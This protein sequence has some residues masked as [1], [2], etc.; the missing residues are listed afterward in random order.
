M[1]WREPRSVLLAA[2]IAAAVAVSAAVAGDG[3]GLPSLSWSSSHVQRIHTSGAPAP[4]RLHGP[5]V[6]SAGSFLTFRGSVPSSDN[7]PVTIL[8]SLDGGPWQTSA[9]ADGSSGSYSA[10][11]ALNQRGVVR[12]RVVFR[13]GSEGIQTIT[14]T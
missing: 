13:D 14:V 12:V 5:S 8:A 10:R 7:G 9:V 6:V 4:I 3:F 11:I 1:G 2:A